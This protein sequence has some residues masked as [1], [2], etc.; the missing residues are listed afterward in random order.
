MFRMRRLFLCAGIITLVLNAGLLSAQS[1]ATS[2]ASSG[3]ATPAPQA[4]AVPQAT[5]APAAFFEGSRLD[6]GSPGR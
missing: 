4:T 3:S 6:E 1:D 2:A 5:A